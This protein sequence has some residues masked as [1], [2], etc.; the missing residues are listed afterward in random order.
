[1]YFDVIYLVVLIAS[2]IYYSDNQRDFIIYLILITMGLILFKPLFINIIGKDYT[3]RWYLVLAIVNMMSLMVCYRL[4]LPS[5]VAILIFIQVV[6]YIS[7]ILECTLL[8][9]IGIYKIINAKYFIYSLNILEIP[10]LKAR[11]RHIG[12]R[13]N[14]YYYNLNSDFM[15]FFS[16]I[17]N[18]LFKKTRERR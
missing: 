10:A 15:V 1:M 2:L 7:A 13:N 3:I 18:V 5:F 11:G 12:K 8:G 9:T 6:V 16:H 14:K 17:K 4:S